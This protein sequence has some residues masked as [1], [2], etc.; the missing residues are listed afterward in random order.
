MAIDK[1]LKSKIVLGITLGVGVIIFILI[2]VYYTG[3]FNCNK[4]QKSEHLSLE[5]QMASPCCDKKA[6]WGSPSDG[7][8]CRPPLRDSYATGWK[9][10]K[11]SVPK[12]QVNSQ[13]LIPYEILTRPQ[14]LSPPYPT[15]SRDCGCV[16]KF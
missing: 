4:C 10:L 12:D 15:F 9:G 7:P 2:I 8:A 5:D 11:Y 16:C 6:I 1:K 3:G 14:L 13:L